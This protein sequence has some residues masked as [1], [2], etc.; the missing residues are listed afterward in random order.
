MG[1]AHRESGF[2]P[3]IIGP[4]NADGS[5]D[6]GEMG[7]NTKTFSAYTISDLQRP[8]VNIP[9]GVGL[10]A[11]KRKGAL[12]WEGAVVAYNHGSTDGADERHIIHLMAVVNYERELD[13]RFGLRF[14]D[15][16]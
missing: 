9:L 8:E 14:A 10:L 2:I 1:E 3:T 13:R 5:R 4:V 6:I 16:L 7:C 12:T 11:Q 15:V